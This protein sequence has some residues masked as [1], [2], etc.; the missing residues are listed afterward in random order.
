[1]TEQSRL[2]ADVSR[3]FDSFIA[4]GSREQLERS[5]ASIVTRYADRDPADDYES[6]KVVRDI[7]ATLVSGAINRE[8]AKTLLARAATDGFSALASELADR[9]IRGLIDQSKYL[10]G[11]AALV[12]LAADDADYR[13]ANIDDLIGAIGR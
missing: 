11:I 9:L 10:G 4:T 12:S 8:T 13:A 1:M 2:K 7:D 6:I 3:A 5:I